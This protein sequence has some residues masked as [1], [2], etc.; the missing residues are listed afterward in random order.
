MDFFSHFFATDFM[1]HG[2]GLRWLSVAS[3]T[4]IALSCFVIS[5]ALIL[6]VR[7]RVSCPRRRRSFIWFAAFMVACGMTYSMAV[8]MAWLPEYRLDARLPRR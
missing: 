1:P 6:Y 2:A 4:L 8:A 3:E 7:K 5:G